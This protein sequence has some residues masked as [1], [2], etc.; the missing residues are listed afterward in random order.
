METTSR[1]TPST[2]GRTLLDMNAYQWTVL[3]AAWL[4]WGFDVFDGLLFNY[5]A[6]NC[7]PTLL[8][9][10]IGTAPAKAAT[11]QWTGIL[12]SILLIGWACGGIFFGKVTDRIGRTK[13]LLLTMALYSIGTAACAFTPN[14]GM[15]I[16]FRCIAAL[17]I[18]GEWAA[19][20]AMVAEVVPEKRRIE[21]GALLYTSAP[22]GL[23][24][25]T[26]LNKIITANFS[27]HPEVSWRYVF[28][29][30]L[31]PAAAAFL[32]R[33]FVKEPERWKEAASQAKA[34]LVAELFS[35]E[36]RALTISGFCMAVTALITWWSCNAF[37]PV[38]STGLAQAQA[39]AN[40][41]SKLETSKLAEAWKTIATNSFNLGGLIGTLLTIP[42]AKL[43][44]RKKMFF[45]YYLLSAAAVMGTF[46]LNMEPHQRLYMYFLIGLTVF[47]VFGSFTYYLPE[48][49]PTRLRGTGAGFCYNVGRFIAAGGPFLVGWIASHGK[50][51]LG[52]AMSAL[53]WV[54]VV[55]LL[56]LLTM[57]WVIETKGRTLLD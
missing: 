12:T 36:Y 32:V 24:L 39:A 34:P 22:I 30:G 49:F 15:L 6:P 54:G 28:L 42:A 7:V 10:P 51:S 41:L 17:G 27:S 2:A 3:F 33:I 48:L 56:G 44:G 50:D 11:L 31:I 23:F 5:V 43:L 13:T 47:G 38:V 45:I 26:F 21:A 46:G 55:P 25:A 8:G 9:I 16:L 19:G 20:A 40:G 18:G 52:L 4:G 37:I 53:F 1:P 29:C 35:P 14:L 57:P